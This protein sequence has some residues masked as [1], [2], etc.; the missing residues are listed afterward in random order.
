[1]NPTQQGLSDFRRAVL[2]AITAVKAQQPQS[3]LHLVY[4]P[5]LADPLELLGDSKRDVALIKPAAPNVAGWPKD[6]CPRLITLD[7]RRVA[8][9]MLETDAGMDDPLMES[10]IS[11]SYAETLLQQRVNILQTNDDPGQAERAVCGWIVSPDT[12]AQ[13]GVRISASASG[14][15]IHRRR[16]WVRWYNPDY[17]EVLWPT[18][19][20]AQKQS[21]LGQGVWIAH[22]SNGRLKTYAAG[23]EAAWSPLPPTAVRLD[24]LQWLQL[25]NVPL[26]QQLLQQW[27][28]LCQDTA[29]PLQPDAQ[30]QLHQWVHRARQLGLDGEDIAV[31]AITA[32]QMPSGFAEDAEWIAAVN[33]AVQQGDKLSQSLPALLDRYWAKRALKQQEN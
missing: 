7:C 28:N 23:H 14:M 16:S 17:L 32:M 33:N 31:Y 5:E 8:A 12:A 10:S 21:L 2:D 25:E 1:M 9:Y 20:A 4:A 6:A 26:V 29:R 15:D 13:I 24:T 18:L 27:K 22:D 30:E 3:Y 19:T 11:Q